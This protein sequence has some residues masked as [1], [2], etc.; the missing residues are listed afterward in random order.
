MRKDSKEVLTVLGTHLYMPYAA[1]YS[2]CPYCN[3][4]CGQ[5]YPTST[6]VKEYT[7]V[8][9]EFNLYNTKDEKLLWSGETESVYSKNFG[10]L[11]REYARALVTQLKKDK[12]IGTK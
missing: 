2:F 11:A 3:R 7:Y 4:S 10:K 1:S 9:T 6:S 5:A 8:S 12:V